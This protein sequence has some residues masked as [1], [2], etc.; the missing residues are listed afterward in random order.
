MRLATINDLEQ[1]TQLYRDTILTVNLKDYSAEQTAVWASRADN[2]HAWAGKISD[3]H[4]L[5]EEEGGVI[6]GFSSLTDGGHV[7]MLFVHKD[8]QGKGVAGKLLREIEQEAGRRGITRLTT[9]AS[10]TARPVFEHFGFSVITEQTVM[11]DG[12]ALNNFKMAR[13]L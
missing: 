5:L 4:F 9:D 11:V 8:H 1:I 12:V 2:T 6:T 3:Q 10:K 7:D 13:S